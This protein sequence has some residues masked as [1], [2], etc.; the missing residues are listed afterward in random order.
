DG[1]IDW[2][3]PAAK[4]FNRTRGF[5]PWPG[6]YSYFRSQM[7]HIWRSR[8]STDTMPGPPGQLVSEKKRLLVCCGE[9]TSLEPL[10]VQIEGRKRMPIEA[11][12]NG[13][14]LN[15]NEM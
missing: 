8:V 3:W 1:L 14:R 11:F 10:E 4:I 15:E 6:A 2:N 13:Q 12:L 7:F 5:L 9:G